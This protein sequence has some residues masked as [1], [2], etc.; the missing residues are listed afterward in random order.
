MDRIRRQ[1]REQGVPEEWLGEKLHQRLSSAAAGAEAFQG[2][3]LIEGE[4]PEPP[5]DGYIEWGGDYFTKGFVVDPETGTIDYRRPIAQTS[6]EAG[7][8]LA[9]IIPPKP[10]KEGRDVFGRPIL[11]GKGAFPVLKIGVNVREDKSSGKFYAVT[12]GRIRWSGNTL[13]VDEVYV[14]EGNVG[15]ETGHISHP[16]ALVVKG[17]IEPGAEVEVRG[18]IEVDGIIERADVSAGGDLVV[19]GGILGR[20]EKPIRVAGSIHARFVIDAALEAEGDV[21]VEREIVQC[22]IKTRGSVLIERGR[23]VGGETIALTGVAA[24]Q[25]S[26]EA[27]VRTLVIAGQDYRL[28]G[29]IAEIESQIEQLEAQQKKVRQSI[30]PLAEREGRMSPES[31]QTLDQFRQEEKQIEAEIA[32]LQRQ[33]EELKNESKAQARLSIEVCKIAYP[34]TILC[35]GHERLRIKEDAPGPVHA[36]LLEGDVKLCPGRLGRTARHSPQ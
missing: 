9:K 1:L 4:R 33:I 20:G 19:R 11:P 16:G 35:L 24:G 36:L 7:D 18:D 8:L 30:A 31:K 13:S 29:K 32:Q 10:G 23:L 22:L 28:P 2:T 21:T 12:S 34:E 6:V 3:V 15:L 17:D 27:A 26:S 25:T 14:I 5:E